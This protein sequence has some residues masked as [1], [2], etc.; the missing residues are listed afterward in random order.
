MIKRVWLLLF[1]LIATSVFAQTSWRNFVA[2]LRSEAIAK[3]I[4]PEV[5]DEAFQ[6]IKAPHNE[7]LRFDRTQP[8]KRI[9]YLHYRNSRASQ[10]RIVIGRS[11]V[12]KN[13]ELLNRIASHY[14]VDPCF[15]ASLWG[16]ETSY[17][18]FMG[19]YSVIQSL[20]TLAYDERRGPIFRRELFYALEML[21][22]G[23]VSLQ[24]L[25][26]E[27]A[28]ATGQPQFL[29][30]TWHNYAVDYDGDGHK[31]IWR[32]K[33]D[34]FASIANYLSHLGWQANQPWTI[35]VSLPA[36]FDRELLSLKTV[37]TVSEW[38]QL[39]VRFSGHDTESINPQLPASV[40][41]PDGG[42]VMMVFNNFR[43]IMK[44]NHSTYYAGTVG[45]M[46]HQICQR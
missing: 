39:G 1:L 27:W 42:P 9:T 4:R 20:A 41:E 25:K 5:F 40:I 3:G 29:P 2:G 43:V 26:G 6:N 38:E 10:D 17:G 34:V 31:D 13:R 15:I 33:G 36:N 14:Q 24:D 7:V 37:K 22:N 23:D 35:E 46:A 8:E 16:L 45:Y 18:R 11:E 30:S 28:G 19:K 44:W 12:K 21:N 32:S